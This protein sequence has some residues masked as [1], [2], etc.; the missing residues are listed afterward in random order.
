MLESPIYREIL[1]EGMEA[2]I[3]KGQELRLR[4]DILAVLQVRFGLVSAP[5]EAQVHQL[6]E[7]KTLEALHRRAILVE[8]LAV[9]SQEVSELIAQ[10]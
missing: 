1:E 10:E 5:L 4:E 7:Q 3:E 2:G 9:F 8:S 6:A